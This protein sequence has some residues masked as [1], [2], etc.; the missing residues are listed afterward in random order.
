MIASGFCEISLAAVEERSVWAALTGVLIWVVP[1]GLVAATSPG[2]LAPVA[3]VYGTAMRFA[4]SA[5][6]ASRTSRL[7]LRK[8]A[9]SVKNDGDLK[10]A[11]P[12]SWQPMQASLAFSING[13]V[14]AAAVVANAAP[15]ITDESARALDTHVPAALLL[16]D[17]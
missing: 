3:V 11:G 10:S 15:A 2:M 6:T 14:T 12:Y 5:E 17:G 13:V 4:F 16:P 9:W 7:V 1:S 8:P